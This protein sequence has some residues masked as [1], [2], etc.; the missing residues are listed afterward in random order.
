MN[1]LC[2]IRS[3][4]QYPNIFLH[5][6]SFHFLDLLPFP[7]SLPTAG[8]KNGNKIF[9]MVP[10]PPSTTIT[11]I[12]IISA[13]IIYNDN[14]W[15]LGKWILRN[16]QETICFFFTMQN[17]WA[18]GLAANA[19]L[20]L[21]FFSVFDLTGSWC[22]CSIQLGPI[23]KN[24]ATMNGWIDRLLDNLGNFIFIFQFNKKLLN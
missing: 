12:I 19:R 17:G 10:E 8:N 20:E 11:T 9:R 3:M 2:I 21:F 24:E 22:W 6:L 7:L 16:S 13:S 15:L 5:L 1:I 23:F 4:N 14:V 18:A